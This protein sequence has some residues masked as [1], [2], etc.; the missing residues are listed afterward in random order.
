MPAACCRGGSTSSTSSGASSSTLTEGIPSG[1]VRLVLDSS[2]FLEYE[3]RREEKV[4]AHKMW[5]PKCNFFMNLESL[6]ELSSTSAAETV[7]VIPC[8]G[9]DTKVCLNCKKEAHPGRSCAQAAERRSENV[10]LDLAGR[11][12]WQRC[13]QCQAIVE[14]THGCNHM[15]C[16]CGHQFCYK[17]G[18]SYTRPVQE[19]S[20]GKGKGSN[21]RGNTNREWTAGCTCVLIDDPGE[22][23]EWET[24]SEEEEE[25]EESGEQHSLAALETLSS[26]EEEEEEEESSVE[27]VAAN[28]SVVAEEMPAESG[29]T[30]KGK[31]YPAAGKGQSPILWKGEG[32]RLGEGKNMKG[33]KGKGTGPY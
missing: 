6:K 12:G 32:R 18:T 28:G 27:E 29:K 13:P 8:P 5:C 19:A 33:K 7:A 9:C 31:G 24:D 25:E 30:G 26:S 22:G 20:K 11:Q 14:R 2:E 23:E 10:V 16:T 17:C 21:G 15:T 4:S 1:I 3:K